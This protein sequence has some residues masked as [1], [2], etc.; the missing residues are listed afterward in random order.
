[1]RCVKKIQNTPPYWVVFL[2]SKLLQQKQ[3]HYNPQAFFLSFR[4]CCKT[5]LPAPGFVFLYSSDEL[6]QPQ[7][8]LNNP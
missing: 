8:Q 1:M 6:L 4:I 5:N 7:Q 2:R 3:P